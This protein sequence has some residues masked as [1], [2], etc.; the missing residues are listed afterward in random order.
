MDWWTSLHTLT[1]AALICF[2]LGKFH[3]IP[4]VMTIFAAYE[5]SLFFIIMYS[6]FI[7]AAV[8]LSLIRIRQIMEESKIDA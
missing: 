8:V 6:L 1:R 5:Y 2:I 7:A 4:A 3:F